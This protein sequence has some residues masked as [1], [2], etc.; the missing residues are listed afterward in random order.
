MLLAIPAR[1]LYVEVRG[2]VHGRGA[3]V[4]LV[5]QIRDAPALASAVPALE[6]HDQANIASARLL[7]KH[8]QA[9]DQ[10]FVERLVLFLRD[11]VDVEIDLLEHA[12]LLTGLPGGTV[13]WSTLRAAPRSRVRHHMGVPAAQAGSL[14]FAARSALLVCKACVK[15]TMWHTA[16]QRRNAPYY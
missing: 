3:R 9:V 4:Q 5:E 10:L 16:L 15:Y 2:H 14:P 11:L 6:Q 8:D 7:L 12:D 1:I 13:P